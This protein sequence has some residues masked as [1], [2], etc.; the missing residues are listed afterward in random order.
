M[1]RGCRRRRP[2]Q[3]HDARSLRW[4][5]EGRRV[6]DCTHSTTATL[7]PIT[8]VN[9]CVVP[10]GMVVPTFNPLTASDAELRAHD[11]AS[12]PRPGEPGETMAAWE[13]Y[14]RWYLA[15]DVYR[16]GTPAHPQDSGTCFPPP[17]PPGF[18]YVDNVA[19]RWACHEMSASAV[20][21]ARLA[22]APPG[23]DT[24]IGCGSMNWAHLAPAFGS[25]RLGCCVDLPVPSG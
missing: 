9:P 24:D 1:A 3:R 11:F 4:L 2:A 22:G 17:P 18:A 16:C 23:P 6:A 15:G 8:S 12:R 10:D 19:L 14:A 21:I 20:S 25:R 7:R 13:Q 5:C